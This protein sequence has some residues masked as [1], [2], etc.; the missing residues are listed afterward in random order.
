[1]VG[2]EIATSDNIAYGNVVVLS[3]D[4]HVAT[5]IDTASAENESHQQLV[6]QTNKKKK[7]SQNLTKGEQAIGVVAIISIIVSSIVIVSGYTVHIHNVPFLIISYPVNETV[8]ANQCNCS[9]KFIMYINY[10]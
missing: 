4:V 1:M 6:H 10:Y 8:M 9:S 3:S 7:T 2:N 5:N